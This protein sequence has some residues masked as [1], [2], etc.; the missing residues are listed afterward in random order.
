MKNTNL[1]MSLLTVALAA[2]LSQAAVSGMHPAYTAESVRPSNMTWPVGDFDF[3]SNGD[4]AVASWT[5]PYGVFI[6]HNATGP[7]KGT[8]TEFVSGLTET[9]GLVVVHDTVFVMQKDELSALIDEDHD[10]KVDEVRT[11]ANRFSKSTMEKEYAGGLIY[12]GQYFYCAFGDQTINSG[13]AV[14]PMMAG[15]LNGALRFSRDGTVY[16]FAGGFR[17]PLGVGLAFGEM[18]TAENQGGYR[19]SNPLYN[20]RDKRWYG[21]P[22]NPPSVYQPGPYVKTPAKSSFYQAAVWMPYKEGGGAS[23]GNPMVVTK[24]IFKG[25]ILVPDASTSGGGICRNFVEK[26]KGEWQGATMWFARKTGAGGFEEQVV[27]RIKEGPDGAIYCGGNGAN[28]SGWGRVTHKG[29]DRMK[30]SGTVPMDILAVRNLGPNTMEFEF[31]KPLKDAAG[32]DV[33]GSITGN[34]WYEEPTEAYGGGHKLGAAGL[35]INSAVVSADRTKITVGVSGL[36]DKGYVH[37]F[38]LNNLTSSDGQGLWGNEAWYTLNNFGPAEE[39]PDASAKV[40]A[41]GDRPFSV[42]NGPGGEIQVRLD[43]DQHTTFQAQLV[44]LRGRILAVR[45]GMGSA[46]IPLGKAGLSGVFIVRVTADQ[47]VYSQ[48][49]SR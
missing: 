8:M 15:R 27:L 3:F 5:D 43:L 48:L 6:V 25:Q 1:T 18:W 39:L 11:I 34:K 22:V 23:P 29:M 30:L 26:V 44:D 49:V 2:S 9:L 32:A 7:G 19:P 40:R 10:G 17:V 31:T 42:A 33:K 24:G 36:S 21:R 37:H 35:T 47:N 12:D 14:D 41:P 16:P 4:M 13:T 28:G 46:E 20:I 38:Q 45:E